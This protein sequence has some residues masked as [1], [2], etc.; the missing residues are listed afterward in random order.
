[1]PFHSSAQCGWHVPIRAM[2]SPRRRLLPT[3]V[4]GIQSWR[5][6][7][8][9]DL[10]LPGDRRTARRSPASSTQTISAGSVVL[11][12]L[13]VPC[14][15][16]IEWVSDGVRQSRC[17]SPPPQY[18]HPQTN[19]TELLAYAFW[20]REA[21]ALTRHPSDGAFL[22]WSLQVNNDRECVLLSALCIAFIDFYIA[23]HE[24]RHLPFIYPGYPRCLRT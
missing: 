9:A 2:A 4:S 12:A 13:G 7:T 11:F 16:E 24:S 21:L 10:S 3:R 22:L 6:S 14:C 17:L 23:S 19:G 15:R 1:M 20:R 8:G 5:S 18:L